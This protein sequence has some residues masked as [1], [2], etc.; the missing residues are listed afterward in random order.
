MHLGLVQIPTDFQTDQSNILVK[1]YIFTSHGEFMIPTADNRMHIDTL[2][3]C[4]VY[5]I[6]VCM[7]VYIYIYIYMYTAANF[8]IIGWDYAMAIRHLFRD[9]SLPEPT[10]IICQF[11][12]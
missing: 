8:D 12:H 9:K 11:D 6:Y 4:D 2:E 5:D 7:Y 3:L 1:I 10:G